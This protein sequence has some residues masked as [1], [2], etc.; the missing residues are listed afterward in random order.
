MMTK[1]ILTD[2]DLMAFPP[3]TIH[4][5]V[6]THRFALESQYAHKDLIEQIPG[7]SY[8]GRGK[9]YWRVP[10]TYASLV[11]LRN[12][13]GDALV[14]DEDVQ[15]WATNEWTNRIGPS[16]DLRNGIVDEA[17]IES[18][19]DLV[20]GDRIIKPYQASA[21]LFLA[22]AR[23]ALLTDDMGT[24]KTYSV[25]TALSLYKN[26]TLPALI[27]CPKSVVYTWQHELGLIGL[28][29]LVIEGVKAKREKLF[30]E[31]D[32]EVTPVVII[33]WSLLTAHSRVA[34]YG[35]KKLSDVEKLPKELNGIHWKTVVADEMHRAK[36][37]D[38]AQTRALWCL[39][40]GPETYR[41]GLTGTPIESDPLDFYYLLRWIDPVTYPSRVKFQDRYIDYDV[42]WF[43]A[44]HVK[45]LKQPTK[46]EFEFITDWRWRRQLNKLDVTTSF[47]Y[48]YC[49][50]AARERRTYNQMKNQLMS[51]LAD[52]N[53]LLADGPMVA[54][55]RLLQMANSALSIEDDVVTPIE[56]S[57]KLDLLQETL[58]DLDGL[59]TIIW[60]SHRKLLNLA[61]A[62]FEKTKLK[63]GCI[64]GDVSSKDRF[65]LVNQFQDGEID[66]ILIVQ[67][68][69]SE[70][71]TLTRAGCSVY[72][73]LD[74][75]SILKNQS[76]RRNLRLGTE[77]FYGHIRY[78]YLVTEN[79]AEE[80]IFNSMIEKE[81]MAQEILRDNE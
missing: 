60:F 11:L 5:D 19:I 71:L 74:H 28:N 67:K 10:R 50:L 65:D 80:N 22:T 73:E 75:S 35:N 78:I 1:I 64:H 45:G 42:D 41:W 9:D 53:V 63:F 23:Q 61:V 49:K 32:S 38:A 6:E 24:G 77:K 44:V 62:R 34:G 59:P 58:A 54:N 79:T 30:E 43:G 13:F 7:S 26:D 52:E 36:S 21:A 66:Y 68:S 55:G 16:F 76:E 20:P 47:E 81:N 48:R 69:G 39:G 56:P 40:E 72:C 70:G 29:T 2:I 37:P 8:R 14:L 12:M 57:A 4:L 46:D 3:I 17:L 25:A 15:T 18:V 33:P 51:E 31:F 27:I